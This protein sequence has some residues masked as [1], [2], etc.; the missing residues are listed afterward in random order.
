[1]VMIAP[2]SRESFCRLAERLPGVYKLNQFPAP[3]PPASSDDNQARIRRQMEERRLERE[4]PVPQGI[5]ELAGLPPDKPLQRK[6][7]YR[8]LFK[9][10]AAGAY[11]QAADKVR[12]CVDDPL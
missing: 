10:I 2:E 8:A 11:S 9:R 7:V 12:R 6:D 3:L 5:Y 4:Q 1:M